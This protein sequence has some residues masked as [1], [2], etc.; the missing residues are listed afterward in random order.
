MLPFAFIAPGLVHGGHH[1]FFVLSALVI[2]ALFCDNKWISLFLIYIVLWQLWL[3]I[4]ILYVSKISVRQVS[5]G[6]MQII[7]ALSAAVIFHAVRKSTLSLEWF[8]NVICVTAM[9][10]ALIAIT[11]M[12]NSDPIFAFLNTVATAKVKL[13]ET[14]IVGTLSNPNFLA[15]YLVFSFPFFLRI[16]KPYYKPSWCWFIPVILFLLVES[17]TSIAVGALLVG[18]MVY[19]GNIQIK[20]VRLYFILALAGV[21]YL[22]WD[23]NCK[24]FFAGTYYFPRFQFWL[25][26]VDTIDSIP[27]IIFGIG[28]AAPKVWGV[29]APMHNDWLTLF[30]QYGFIGLSFFIGYIVTLYRGNKMLFSA[31]IIFLVNMIGNYPVHLAPSAFLI[32][33]IAGLLQREKEVSNA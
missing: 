1:L 27:K 15:A 7:F 16:R 17:K 32:V 28:P 25:K 11:Q 30:Y 19:F 24:R 4:D 22:W 6:F 23:G 26:T 18:M 14:V 12:F 2:I 31:F 3:F 29:N 10:Q 20:G 13:G 5:E 33:I 8:Y 9:I 21:A